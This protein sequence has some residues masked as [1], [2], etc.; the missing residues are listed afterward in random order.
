MRATLL[1]SIHAMLTKR[2]RCLVVAFRQSIKQFYSFAVFFQRDCNSDTQYARSRRLPN[3]ETDFRAL[4]PSWGFF[5]I[6]STQINSISFYIVVWERSVEWKLRHNWISRKLATQLTSKVSLFQLIKNYE[7]RKFFL[8]TDIKH[9]GSFQAL[10]R[11]MSRFRVNQFIF[12]GTFD[13]RMCQVAFYWS[14]E[15]I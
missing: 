8:S 1:R 5:F 3:A 6:K 12:H 11:F 13:D 14:I 2:H 9:A 4:P 15:I 10:R 7:P